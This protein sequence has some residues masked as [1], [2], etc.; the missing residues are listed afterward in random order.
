MKRSIGTLFPDFFADELTN[1]DDEAIAN[2]SRFADMGARKTE[3]AEQ[4]YQRK[5]EACFREIHRVLNDDGVLTVMFTH[6]R[7]EAWDTLGA[8]LINA[9]FS[10]H[11]SW[12]VHTESEHSLHQAKKNAAASTILLT[13]RKRM[14]GRNAVWWD[15]LKG[16]VRETAREKAAEYE[17]LGIRGVDLYI[18]TFGPVLSVISE[19][20]PVLTSEVDPKTNKPKALRPEA[21]LEIAREEVVTLRKKGLLLGREVR[22]DSVTDWYLLAWDAFRAEQ[23]PADEAR[24]LC[25]ALDVDMEGTVIG[26]KRLLTKKGK[27]VSLVQP[28]GRRKRGMVDPEAEVFDCLLDAGHT[29]MLIFD[30]DGTRTCERWLRQHGFDRDERFRALL[31]AMANAIPNARM[32]GKYIRPEM[33]LLDRMN[34]ALGLG[35]T[36]PVEPEPD[37]RAIQGTLFAGGKAGGESDE[38]LEADDGGDGEEEDEGDA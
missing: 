24:K 29:A 3:L 7:V 9:G 38:D 37:L 21:A 4:D 20:W 31:Q 26:S 35:I 30:E 23:F 1:K 8:S 13:C 25:I 11:S 17:T 2:V 19:R 18:A 5:M 10:V 27:N 6:K 28:I 32:K 33:S 22:F 36:F 12:P 14:E 34:D 16:L 15:D